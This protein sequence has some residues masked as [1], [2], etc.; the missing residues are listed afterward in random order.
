M[1]ITI[2]ILHTLLASAGLTSG[3][4]AAELPERILL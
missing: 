3:L 4:T 2:R 1:K